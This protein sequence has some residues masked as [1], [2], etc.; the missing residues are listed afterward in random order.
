MFTLIP[1]LSGALESG[2]QLGQ[3]QNRKMLTIPQLKLRAVW[4]NRFAS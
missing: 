4:L 1:N 3:L 2:T